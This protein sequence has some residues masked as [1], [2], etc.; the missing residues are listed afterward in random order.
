[1]KNMID[2]NHRQP[3][4]TVDWEF[5]YEMQGIAP[6]RV[7]PDLIRLDAE[8]LAR[9]PGKWRE[10]RNT[11]SGHLERRGVTFIALADSENR[12]TDFKVVGVLHDAAGAPLPFHRV[13]IY[14]KDHFED[15]YIGSLISDGQG[16]FELS[17]GKSVFSDFGMESSPDIYFKVAAWRGDRFEEIA[18]ITPKPFKTS[19]FA[20]GKTLI[21]FG[22]VSVP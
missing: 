8:L 15:D 11:L 17:F 16:R 18:R 3:I 7:S 2:M 6:E 22:T 20:D 12:G 5:I 1:M 10:M 14:D 4:G 9:I 19:Q 21:D 13:L